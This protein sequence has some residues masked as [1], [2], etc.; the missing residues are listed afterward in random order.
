MKKKTYD[1]ITNIPIVGIMVDA[2]VNP[3]FFYGSNEI[4][5]FY[6]PGKPLY[7]KVKAFQDKHPNTVITRSLLKKIMSK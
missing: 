5:E 3:F 6:Q 4:Q 7:D 1:L 2:V